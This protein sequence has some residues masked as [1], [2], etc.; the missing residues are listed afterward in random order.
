MEVVLANK[1]SLAKCVEE[2]KKREPGVTG[3]L[4]MK[5]Q[6][7]TSGKTSQV[8]VV[9]DEFKGTYMAGCVGGL[10]KGWVFPRHKNQGE[11]IQFPFKF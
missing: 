11:P 1:P 10:I 3:K 7:Q 4:V 6:I 9:T 2:Q 5:W 8:S